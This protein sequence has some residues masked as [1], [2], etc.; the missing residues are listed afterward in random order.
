MEAQIASLEITHNMQ[1]GD[2]I[3]CI[4]FHPTAT[5]PLLATGDDSGTTKL[6]NFSFNAERNH[7]WS[8]NHAATLKTNYTSVNCIAFSPTGTF[9]ATGSHLPQTRKARR[10]RK[11]RAQSGN[12]QSTAAVKP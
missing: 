11:W 1:R 2:S 8:V 7:N 5:P 9:L 4:A 12:N 10:P 6:W 3:N